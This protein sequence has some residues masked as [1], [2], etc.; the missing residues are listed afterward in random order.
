MSSL[1]YPTTS[2]EPCNSR[3]VGWLVSYGIDTLG[4]AYEIRAGR[5][6]ITSTPS[7]DLR[8]IAVTERSVSSPHMAVNAT[9]KHRVVIQDIFSEHGTFIT[10]NGDE[11]EQRVS[12]PT[13]LD[14]GDRLRIGETM[15]F[16]VCLI[17]MGRR[18]VTQ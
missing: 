8:T 18:G 7:S 11:Q 12:G 9:P 3:L 15:R 10:K 5:L 17:D 16:Q 1:N 4:A 14:H 6:L 2:N 13:P